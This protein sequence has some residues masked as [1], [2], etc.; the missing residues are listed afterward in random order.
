MWHDKVHRWECISMHLLLGNNEESRGY[1]E[2][3]AK[4]SEIRV[5]KVNGWE[6]EGS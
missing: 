2:Y 5:G 1:P 6:T 3:E 4:M